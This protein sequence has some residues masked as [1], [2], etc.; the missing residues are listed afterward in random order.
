MLSKTPT[1][2]DLIKFLVKIGAI[3]KHHILSAAI[4]ILSGA[5]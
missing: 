1:R 4:D 3:N 5:V 2:M